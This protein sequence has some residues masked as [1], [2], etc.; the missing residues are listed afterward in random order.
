MATMKKMKKFI[1]KKLL[2]NRQLFKMVP[3]IGN[4]A[5]GDPYLMLPC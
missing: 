5:D 1:I 2:A 4:Y 3:V